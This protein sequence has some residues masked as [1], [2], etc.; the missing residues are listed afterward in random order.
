MAKA[1][2]DYADNE[3]KDDNLFLL[4]DYNMYSSSESAYQTLIGGQTFRFEDP[5]NTSGNWNN[6]GSFASV[7]TQST[8]SSSSNSCFSAGGL[9]DRF[10]QILCSEAVVEGDDQM[11]FVPNTYFAVGN[12]GN[13]FNSSINSGTNYSVSSTVLSALYSLS[14]HL[15]VIADFDVDM[16]GLST[17]EFKIPALPNPMRQPFEFGGYTNNYSLTLVAMDGR[18]VFRKAVNEHKILQQLPTGVY[19]ALWTK[20]GF[21]KASKLMVW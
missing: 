17:D 3:C 16:Q 12:D 13:H 15:P 4:G 7:H 2:I 8:R 21:T 18:V 20:K 11:V 6:N 5:I 19:T 9:D 1:V 10:D 14:D